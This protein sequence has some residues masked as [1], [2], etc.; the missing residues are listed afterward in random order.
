MWKLARPRALAKADPPCGLPAALAAHPSLLAG[1]AT[2]IPEQS[3]LFPER[4][5]HVRAPSSR[6]QPSACS[7]CPPRP[8]SPAAPLSPV[9]PQPASSLKQRLEVTTPHL[10]LLR[11][12]AA[13]GSVLFAEQRG[14]EPGDPRSPNHARGT[15]QLSGLQAP[16][17][18][19]K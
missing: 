19:S 2:P 5:P 15:G 18:F 17:F 10:Q 1:I 13:C 11:G 3:P 8:G 12:A 16:C 9:L 7:A 6:A 4:P 14:P